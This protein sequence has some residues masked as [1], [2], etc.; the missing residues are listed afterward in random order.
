MCIHT[1]ECKHTSIHTSECKQFLY[2]SAIC[3][4]V[5][6]CVCAYVLKSNSGETVEG[7]MPGEEELSWDHPEDKG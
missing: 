4:S 2:Y 5:R 3:V 6:A 7:R 1:S